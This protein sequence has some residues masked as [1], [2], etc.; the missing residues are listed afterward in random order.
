MT[1]TQLLDLLPEVNQ[2]AAEVASFQRQELAV[3]NRSAIE[4][5][6][7]HDL[8]SYVDRQSEEMI[9]A[10]LQQQGREHDQAGIAVAIWLP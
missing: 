1:Q 7:L 6:G 9:V 5:K 10:R 4:H 2:L 8:V 3:F